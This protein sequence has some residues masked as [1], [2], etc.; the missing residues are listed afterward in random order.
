MYVLGAATLG[1]LLLNRHPAEIVMGDV[2][3]GFIAF[4]ITAITMASEKSFSNAFVN[5][6]NGETVS[7]L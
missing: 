1:F 6:D 2:C 4:Y 5:A 7:K 3:S